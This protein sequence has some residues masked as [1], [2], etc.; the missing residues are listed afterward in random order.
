MRDLSCK[1]E[2]CQATLQSFKTDRPQVPAPFFSALQWRLDLLS[3]E[4]E[5]TKLMFREMIILQQ[6]DPLTVFFCSIKICF[7]P[8]AR[9]GGGMNVC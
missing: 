9:L 1:R 2:L 5:K 8:N 3:E 6:S 4:G 7:I